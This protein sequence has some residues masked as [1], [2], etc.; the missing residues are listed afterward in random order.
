VYNYSVCN[1]IIYKLLF[2]FNRDDIYQSIL[3]VKLEK[4]R[5]DKLSIPLKVGL[6]KKLVLKLN[7]EEY[8]EE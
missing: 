4:N 3:E 8:D 7:S 2:T 1:I 5:I 6:I